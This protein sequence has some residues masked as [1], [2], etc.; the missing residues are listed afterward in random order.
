MADYT[1]KRIDDMEAGFRGGFKKA[2]A[3][4][5]VTSFGLQILDFPPDATGHP[6]HEH[7]ADGQEEVFAVLRGSGAL[8]VGGE[9]LALTPEVMVRVGPAETRKII[10]GPDG[11]RLLALG[12]TPGKA[13]ESKSISELTGA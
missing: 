2:R 8:R 5:G 13:Y 4:L 7:A 9:E 1:L 12:G 3:E 6:E 10:S 11:L